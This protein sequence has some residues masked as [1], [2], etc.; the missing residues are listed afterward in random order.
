M[1]VVKDYLDKE[2]LDYDVTVLGIAPEVEAWP[3]DASTPVPRCAACAAVR[4]LRGHLEPVD[5]G[6]DGYVGGF[7]ENG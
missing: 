4:L 3:A 5:T 7:M 2:L 1:T 6:S